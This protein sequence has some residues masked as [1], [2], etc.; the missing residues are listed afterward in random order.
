VKKITGPTPAGG[1]RAEATFL[2]ENGHRCEPDAAVRIM[3]AEYL[4]DELVAETELRAA[5]A[6]EPLRYDPNQPRDPGGEDGGQWVKAGGGDDFTPEAIP[7]TFEEYEALQESV[8]NA[9]TN[10][11]AD[12][13]RDYREI[14]EDNA[15][16]SKIDDQPYPVEDDAIAKIR[17]QETIAAELEGDEDFRSLIVALDPYG[18]FKKEFEPGGKFASADT[19]EKQVAALATATWAKSSGDSDPISLQFQIAAEQEFGLEANPFVHEEFQ[20]RLDYEAE[21]DLPPGD[22]YRDRTIF[23]DEQMA[24]ARKFV[25]TQ[26]NLTQEMLA[27]EGVREVVLYRGMKWPNEPTSIPTEIKSLLST[28]R[29]SG[30]VAVHGNPLSSWSTKYHTADSFTSGHEIRAIAGTKVDARRILSTPYTGF[31][32]LKESEV[33]LLGGKDMD[34]FTWAWEQETDPDNY[35]TELGGPGPNEE[36]E[37]LLVSEWISQTHGRKSKEQVGGWSGP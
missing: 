26:Y 9:W 19:V 27:K 10:Q 22:A 17:V 29:G 25:R 1:D 32:C 24:G 16:V 14:A 36:G 23:T 35:V 18:E 8:D 30:V 21:R 5:G 13:D 4:G 37:W 3:V 11:L 31:G 12:T 6:A 2:D 34:A 33:V 20:K 28:R 7:E 15:R